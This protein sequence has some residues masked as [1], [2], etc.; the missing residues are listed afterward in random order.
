MES[1]FFTEISDFHLNLAKIG[2]QAQKIEDKLIK[3]S[4][5]W[6]RINHFRQQCEVTQRMLAKFVGE[7]K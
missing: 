7:K 5:E 6:A 3:Y 1:K 4:R 2:I